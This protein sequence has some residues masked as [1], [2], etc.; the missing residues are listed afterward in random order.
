MKLQALKKQRDQGFSKIE[1]ILL[2]FILASVAFV[3]T[4]VLNLPQSKKTANQI[5]S[6]APIAQ[7]VTT[8]TKDGQVTFND[9]AAKA[10]F[11]YPKSWAEKAIRG[12]CDE[13]NGCSETTDKIDAVEIQSPDKKV[14]LIW[15][16]ISGVGGSCDNSKPPTQGGCPVETVLNKAPIPGSANLYVVEGAIQVPN[17]QFQPFLAVQDSVTGVL[18]SGEYG[19]W[20]QSFRLPSTGHNT[21]FY[22]DNGYGVNAPMPQ[23]F[24]S[25]T[26]VAAYLSS[27]DVNQAKQILL[28]LKDGS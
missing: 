25:I 17:G 20:Y 19:L 24:S 5:S 15:S 14:D 6:I 22:M 1:A 26:Q 10:S 8:N 2:I 28:S 23:T 16:G 12:L 11:T 4:K 21:L 18:S 7:K 13:P 9:L 27:K 3:G